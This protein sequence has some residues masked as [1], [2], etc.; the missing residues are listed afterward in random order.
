MNESGQIDR[1]ILN[2][3]TGDLWTYGVLDDIKNLAVNASQLKDLST[4]ISGGT[5]DRSCSGP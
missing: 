4:I 1:L 2:D 5:V 3:V